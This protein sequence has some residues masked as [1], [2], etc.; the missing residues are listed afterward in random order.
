MD[1][2]KRIFAILGLLFAAVSLMMFV[3]VMAMG[4]MSEKA[5]WVLIPISL[6]FF[7]GLLSLGIRYLQKLQAEAKAKQ[8]QEK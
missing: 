3:I 5:V 6:F 1:Q 4:Q 8:E 2:I 7:F